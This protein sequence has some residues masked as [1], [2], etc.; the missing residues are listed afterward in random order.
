MYGISVGYARGKLTRKAI[1]HAVIDPTAVMKEKVQALHTD[2]MYR[3]QVSC[4]SCGTTSINYTGP[5]T[6]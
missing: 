6:Q 4:I 5:S 3:A 1:A 2:V